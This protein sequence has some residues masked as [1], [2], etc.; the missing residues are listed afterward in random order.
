MCLLIPAVGLLRRGVY[1][2]WRRAP[3]NDN[4]FDITSLDR[5]EAKQ[6]LPLYIKCRF[7]YFIQYSGLLGA[8]SS[9]VSRIYLDV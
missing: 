4:Q 9:V 1:S 6:S 3:R 8:P 5:V 2:E 7:V